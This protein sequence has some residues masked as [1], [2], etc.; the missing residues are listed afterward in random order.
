MLPAGDCCR[1]HRPAA[2]VQKPQLRRQGKE[3]CIR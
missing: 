2:P 1:C 3:Q